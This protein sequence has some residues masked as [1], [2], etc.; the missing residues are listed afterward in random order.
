M[1]K[2]LCQIIAIVCVFAVAG[3]FLT[4][5]ADAGADKLTRHFVEID[6][7]N[8]YGTYCHTIKY[9]Y[10][11]AD[12]ST[13]HYQFYHLGPTKPDTHEDDHI[14]VV[15]GTYKWSG[16]WDLNTLCDGTLPIYV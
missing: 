10:S 1:K 4:I 7:Y 8:M 2:S 13:Q 16:R 3:L 11:V 12:T 9:N 14:A 15:T 6:V 5:E